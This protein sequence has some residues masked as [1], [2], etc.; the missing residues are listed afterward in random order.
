MAKVRLTKTELKLQKDN[1]K[2]FMRYL[3][4]LELKKHQLLAEIRRIQS[5]VDQLQNRILLAEHEIEPWA[6]VFSAYGGFSGLIR[7]RE[8]KASEGNIAGIAIPVLVEVSFEESEYDMARTPLWVDTALPLVFAQMR[9]HIEKRYAERQQEI[10]REELRVT[11][12]RIKLFEN[13]KIPEAREAI[14]VIQIFLGDVRTA[15]VV[16][17]KIAKA[18]I[19]EK[20]L[21]AVTP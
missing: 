1:L 9:R 10:L 19:I 7:I 3:P 11:I 4:T 16:R 20:S 17:G 6:D 12:Q 13:V 5:T 14:R 8:I 21:R 2:R 15:E 18:K